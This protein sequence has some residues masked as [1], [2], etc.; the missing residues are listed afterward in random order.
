M[1]TSSILTEEQMTLVEPADDQMFERE[2]FDR[3]NIRYQMATVD[4][5]PTGTRYV[6]TGS[7]AYVSA[8]GTDRALAPTAVG[9][10]GGTI[11]LVQVNGEQHELVRFTHGF[12][13][14]DEDREVNEELVTN[15]R[16]GVLE[17]FDFEADAAFLNGITDEDGNVVHKSALQW[18]Q[19]AV[20]GTAR[21]ID[22]ST[23]SVD[24]DLDGVPANII[25]EVAYG[26]VSG[27]LVTTNWGMAVGKHSA[28]ARFSGYDSDSTDTT[29]WERIQAETDADVGVKER[30]TIPEQIAL[31]APQGS[32][33]RIEVTVDDL[34]SDTIILL[35]EQAGEVFWRLYENPEPRHGEPVRKEGM[36]ERHEYVWRHRTV[37]DPDNRAGDAPDAI[38]L[39]NVSSLF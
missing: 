37:F 30:M 13:L 8:D 14:L 12:N 16:D 22:C 3:K 17:L 2:G 32:S 25:K 28:L 34:G 24:T 35:P 23:Y 7:Q 29:H 31:P 5:V 39:Q 6:E 21:T 20:S 4:E 19:D 10:S 27:E 18:V 38:V 26:E 33:E 15:M 9:E 1:A 11:D 36:K